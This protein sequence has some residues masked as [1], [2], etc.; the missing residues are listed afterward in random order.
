MNENIHKTEIYETEK[1]KVTHYSD[2]YWGLTIK[3]KD[4]VL[5]KEEVIIKN[6]DMEE[7]AEIFKEVI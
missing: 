7:L 3:G 5:T 4:I 2:G 6:D 1:W